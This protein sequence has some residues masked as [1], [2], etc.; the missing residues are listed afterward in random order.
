MEPVSY[1]DDHGMRAHRKKRHAAY[2]I[3]YTT[4]Y[5]AWQA[6]GQKKIPHIKCGKLQFVGLDALQTA[7][8]PDTRHQASGAGY[9][10]FLLQFNLSHFSAKNLWLLIYNLRAKPFLLNW[11]LVPGA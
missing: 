4:F 11:C 6:I 10:V 2:V 7:Q 8:A 3:N 5:R 1:H 9:I